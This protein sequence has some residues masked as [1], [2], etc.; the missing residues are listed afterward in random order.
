MTFHVTQAATER[1]RQWIARPKRMLIGGAWVDA[2]SGA[3]FDT[4]D[5]AD[6]SVLCAVPLG[7][8]REIDQAVTAARKALEQSRVG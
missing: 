2:A 6:G 1:A 3:T 5:P 4:L 7:G 8:A